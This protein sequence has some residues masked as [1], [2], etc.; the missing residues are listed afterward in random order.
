MVMRICFPYLKNK[1]LNQVE[2]PSKTGR[3]LCVVG[4]IGCE[5]VDKTAG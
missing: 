2:P 1:H 3:F 4:E 5:L